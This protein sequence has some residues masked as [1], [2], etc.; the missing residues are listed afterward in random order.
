MKYPKVQA[1]EWVQPRR[2]GYK[3]K[4][5]DCGLVHVM[6]FQLLPFGNNRKK[7]QFRAWREEQY[8]RRRKSK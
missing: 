8:G 1:G 5:C 2:K 6:E 7:I 3:M 4:C